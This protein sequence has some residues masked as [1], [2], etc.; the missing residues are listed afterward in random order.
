MDAVEGQRLG[1]LSAQ[2]DDTSAWT[3]TRSVFLVGFMGAGKTSVARKLARECGIASVDLDRYVERREGRRISDIFASEGEEVFRC[4][5]TDVLKEMMRLDPQLIS[6]GGGVVERDENRALL[7]G[8]YVVYL[9]V[10]ADEAANRIG[11]TGS[12]PLFRDLTVARQ[13]IQERLPLY[14]S[15]ADATVDTVGKSLGA[16]VSEVRSVLEKE[17]VLCLQPR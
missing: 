11:D 14:E 12:R 1:G 8:G 2:P 10:S 4:L 5:E 3:L 15:V 17:G 6:C 13:R 7:K 16:I 9:H